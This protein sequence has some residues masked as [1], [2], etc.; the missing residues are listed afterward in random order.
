MG[1]TLIFVD[2]GPR[3]G[4]HE[5]VPEVTV[6]STEADAGAVTE[7]NDLEPKT[8]LTPEPE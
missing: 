2:P 8:T 7:D 4:N 1:I 3:A 5:V 6:P